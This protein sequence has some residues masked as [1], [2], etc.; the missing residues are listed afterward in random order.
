MRGWIG[1][2]LLQESYTVAGLVSALVSAELD[3]AGVPSQ[4]F[5]LLGWITLLEPVT[6]A[7]LTA[8][9][10]IPTTTLRDYLRLLVER[11]DVERRPNEADRRSYLVVT[12]EQGRGLAD[13]GIPAVLRAEEAVVAGL[14]G[15]GKEHLARVLE[16]KEA[17]KGALAE[18][19]RPAHAAR[20]DLRGASERRLSP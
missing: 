3:E 18:R 4:L 2:G 16:L 7:R 8:E 9:T 14:P 1:L 13:R 20:G 6:P 15:D 11:G 19:G 17:V 10:G 5:S 12:T